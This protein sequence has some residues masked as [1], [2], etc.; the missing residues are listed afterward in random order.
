M[1]N[2]RQ[3]LAIAYHEAGHAVAC[4]FFHVKVKSASI[5]PKKGEYQGCVQ[6][7]GMFRGLRPDIEVSGRARLQIERNIVISLAGAAAQRRHNKKSWRSYHS[8][9][10]FHYAVKL[11]SHV[12]LS[13]A[14][15]EA[16][17]HWLEVRADELIANQWSAVQRIAN[18][19]LERKTVP[20]DEIAALILEQQGVSRDQQQKFREM[21]KRLS[22]T[23]VARHEQII[24]RFKPMLDP[25]LAKIE[26]AMGLESP[27]KKWRARVTSAVA[28][29]TNDEALRH[30]KGQP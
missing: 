21:G 29:I 30:Q 27:D 26:R 24:K 9:S 6:H 4:H 20:G 25:A 28:R 10:D 15:S 16:F 2:K 8:S 14:D 23:H 17:L 1:S 18:V 12:C 13:K 5:V 3:E 11:A 22:A 19:L 7:E